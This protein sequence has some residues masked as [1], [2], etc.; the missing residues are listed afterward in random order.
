MLLNDFHSL[1]CLGVGITI[2][3]IYV[4]VGWFF[5]VVLG[6][7]MN[8]S[9]FG[10]KWDNTSHTRLLFDYFCD[11]FWGNILRISWNFHEKVFKT[12]LNLKKLNLHTILLRFLLKIWQKISF[13]KN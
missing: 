11:C 10:C 1:H 13:K 12:S 8:I 2:I 4:C 3:M 7:N 9:M 5:K 6:G